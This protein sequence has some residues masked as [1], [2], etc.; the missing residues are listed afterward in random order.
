MVFCNT[1]KKMIIKAKSMNRFANVGILSTSSFIDAL[2]KNIDEEKILQ[3]YCM[4]LQRQLNIEITNIDKELYTNQQYYYDINYQKILLGNSI[5]EVDYNKVIPTYFDLISSKLKDSSNFFAP[6]LLESVKKEEINA[7]RTF[8]DIIIA[9]KERKLYKNNEQI[10]N[11][12]KKT[13]FFFSEPE[14]TEKT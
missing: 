3:N 12:E 8:R 9:C 4:F 7:S 1:L 6:Y 10:D 5:E 11:R 14:E 2:E 13:N